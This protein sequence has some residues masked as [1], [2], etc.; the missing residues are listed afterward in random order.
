MIRAGAARIAGI[1]AGALAALCLAFPASAGVTGL[2]DA[3]VAA[4]EAKARAVM[5]AT[6]APSLSIAVVRDGQI[7]YVQAW[8]EARPGVKATPFTRYPIG[9][10]SKQFTATAVL[11]LGDDGKLGLDDPLEAYI[12]GLTAGG[13]ITI[14]QLLGMTAGFRDY[15]PQDFATPEMLTATTNAAL[16]TR[17]ARTPLDYRPGDDWQYSNTSYAVAGALVE[18]A[19]HEPLWSVL[20]TRIFDP[21]SMTSVVSIDGAPLAAPDAQGFTRYAM[22]PVRPAPQEAAGWLFATGDLA[23]NARDLAV[24]DIG[25]INRALLSKT[26]YAAQRKT[27]KLS[28]GRDSGYG[29]GV[30][31]SR[32]NDRLKLSHGGAI[33]GFRAENRVWPDQG[34]A[35]VVMTNADFSAPDVAMADAIERI[36]FP[37][38]DPAQAAR[39]VFDEL[40]AGKLERRQLS[41]NG[42]AYFTPQAVADYAA[43][44]APLGEPKRFDLVREWRRGG[45]V[46]R[47]YEVTYGDGRRLNVVESRVSSGLLDQFTVAPIE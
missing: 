6:G 25:Q 39:R 40:R 43:S 14:R 46:L 27:Q 22:G 1:V 29:L 19:A 16:L 33:S 4:I 17:W 26:S 21:L 15:W 47:R 34:I 5:A 2:T 45:M 35:V 9:S 8:G 32:D 11:M 36:L 24:W 31:V 37:N 13:A 41:T 18:E 30:Y 3:E 23:M 10:I 7:A 42:A 20:K 28:G 12:H 38:D 44:L